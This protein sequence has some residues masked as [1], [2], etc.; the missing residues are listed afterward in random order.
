MKVMDNWKELA[1][2][3]RIEQRVNMKNLPPYVRNGI[4]K[5]PTE[6]IRKTNL[7]ECKYCHYSPP[8]KNTEGLTYYN[9]MNCGSREVHYSGNIPILC[10]SCAIQAGVCVK[11]GNSLD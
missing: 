2:K 5:D 6:L 11:C 4:K 3:T 9:C 1:A 8:K 7:I 10:K